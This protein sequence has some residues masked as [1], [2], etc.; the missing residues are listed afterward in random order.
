MTINYR[1]G[2]LGFMSLPAANVTGN[3]GL[4]D[5]QMALKWIRRHISQFGG[6]PLQITLM[7]WSAGAASIGLHMLAESSRGL[8]QRA[9]MMS[10]SAINPW[11]FNVGVGHCSAAMLE[12]WNLQH[13]TVDGLKVA[14][15]S[16]DAADFVP[17]DLMEIAPF[18]IFGFPEFCFVPTIDGSLTT[19][20]P[21]QLLGKVKADNSVSLMIGATVAE[22]ESDLFSWINAIVP[23]NDSTILLNIDEYLSK[24]F[25]SESAVFDERRMSFV[26]NLRAIV[27]MHFGVWNFA[28]QYGLRTGQPVFLYHFSYAGQFGRSGSRGACHGDDLGYLFGDM[29]R[30]HLELN[31]ETDQTIRSTMVEMWTSFIKNG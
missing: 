27:D 7:G 19:E 3:Y 13:V 15:K 12:K 28:R 20:S 25:Q 26:Y 17:N 16:L 11:A 24:Q 31:A 9:I 2:A 8:F 5:Q 30:R 10:G 23:N 4:L 29:S 14:L 22:I 21:E 6:D 1:M 18:R